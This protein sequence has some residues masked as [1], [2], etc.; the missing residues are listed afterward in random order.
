MPKIKIES[1]FTW[2]DRVKIISDGENTTGI[3]VKLICSENEITYLVASGVNEKE[4]YTTELE[5]V[6]R[7]QKK[8]GNE[9]QDKGV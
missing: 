1:D 4:C 2:N 3:I 5:L 8:I 6:E 9:K 7:P